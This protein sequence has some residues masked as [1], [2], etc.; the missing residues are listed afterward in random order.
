MGEEGGKR[1][2]THLEFGEEGEVRARR[3]DDLCNVSLGHEFG[4][5]G[6]LAGF[7]ARAHEKDNVRVAKMAEN[8]EE[9][10]TIRN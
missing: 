7:G 4:D 10:E 2:D 5:D 9:L 6:E 3:V 1:R 8:N